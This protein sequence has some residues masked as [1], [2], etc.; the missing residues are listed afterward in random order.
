M[1][2]VHV[3]NSEGRHILN[4]EAYRG[5]IAAIRAEVGDRLV[6]QVTSEALGVYPPAEQRAVV[7]DTHPE[8]V[9]LALRE[10]V[11]DGSEE[12]TFADLLAW[13]K[14]E[15]ILP[16]IIL[17]TPDE[18]VRTGRDETTRADPLGTIFRYFMCWAATP[19]ARHLI[20]QICCLS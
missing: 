14:H 20:R 3:R 6:I 15:Q 10:L 18:A 17:Y 12:S 8:A 16:Q 2:H 5:A 9:S 7:R 11:P 1:I 19:P 13:M 4:A